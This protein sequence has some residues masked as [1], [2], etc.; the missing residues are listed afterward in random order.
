MLAPAGR[1]LGALTLRQNEGTRRQEE[2]KNMESNRDKQRRYHATVSGNVQGVGFRHFVV[3][4]VQNE[5][6]SVTGW[7]RNLA[8]GRVEVLAEGRPDELDRL[9]DLLEKGPGRA[10]VND[11]NVEMGEAKGDL[12]GFDVRF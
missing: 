5:L 4:T 7:V 6:P 11:M 1:L 10:D 3:S 8:D 2:S 12:R 9:D